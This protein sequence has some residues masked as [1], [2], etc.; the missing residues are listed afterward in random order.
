MPCITQALTATLIDP[1]RPKVMRNLIASMDGPPNFFN[2]SIQDDEDDGYE[3]FDDQDMKDQSEGCEYASSNADPSGLSTRVPSFRTCSSNSV[4]MDSVR[5]HGP[6]RPT[7]NHIRNESD[8]SKSSSNKA[9]SLELA[10]G[11]PEPLRPHLS[12]PTIAPEDAPADP[13]DNFKDEP[14]TNGFVPSNAPPSKRRKHQ[15]LQANENFGQRIESTKRNRFLERNRAAATKCRQK[16]K[17]WVSDLEETRFGLESQH[18]HLQMEYS[19]LRNEIT[20]IKSQLMEH[21]SC[22]DSNINKWIENEAKKFVLG[23]SERYDQILASVGH[24]PGL[25]NRQDSFSS[26]SGYQLAADSG[27][28]SPITPSQRSSF[29]FPPGALA[30][31]SPIFYRP[32]MMSDLPDSTTPAPAEEPYLEDNLPT[33]MGRDVTNFEN[34]TMAGDPL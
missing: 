29:S 5:L 19:S 23:A 20:Q 9:E 11:S 26:A 15:E 27:L 31:N 3:L 2:N 8:I 6:R 7:K 13:C 18:N 14:E 21:A 10:S 4:S 17:E 25:I 12:Q 33:S 1:L 28:L 22:N 30:S 34:V 16:K 32:E 24:A